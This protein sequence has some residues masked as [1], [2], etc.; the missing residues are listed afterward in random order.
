MPPPPS[1][2][3]EVASH[4]FEMG[5]YA[6]LLFR[7]EHAIV[8]PADSALREYERLRESNQDNRLSAKERDKEAWRAAFLAASKVRPPFLMCW[9]PGTEQ[10]IELSSN[11][12]FANAFDME[13]NEGIRAFAVL[14][15]NLTS[16]FVIT[17]PGTELGERF[18]RPLRRDG[19]QS[20]EEAQPEDESDD[21]SDDEDA[22]GTGPQ[23]RLSLG[24]GAASLAR[25]RTFM[26]RMT[27]L[28]PPLRNVSGDVS[29]EKPGVSFSGGGSWPAAQ[30]RSGT[31]YLPAAMQRMS[32]FNGAAPSLPDTSDGDVSRP[33]MLQRASTYLPSSMQRKQA[34]R[35]EPEASPSSQLQVQPANGL[36]NP[37]HLDKLV[38]DNGQHELPP[39]TGNVV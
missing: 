32:R 14:K 17:R 8:Q 3:W 33:T 24:P 39:R 9:E 37:L 1:E 30:Q 12:D 2:K 11:M 21:E 16:P 4:R 5:R 28:G 7:G 25:S 27:R 13:E 22:A 23:S 19:A 31:S 20:E 10:G 15:R 29:S 34:C 36:V 35:A 38:L 18:R 6:S 26:R